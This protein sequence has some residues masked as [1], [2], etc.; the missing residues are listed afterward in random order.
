M[1][2]KKIFA[3]LPFKNEAHNFETFFQNIYD[4][5]DGVIGFDDGSLDNSS[6]IFSDYG[7][8]ML[9]YDGISNWGKGG[10]RLVRNRLLEF[11]RELG[12]T[13]F[14]VLDADEFISTDLSPF[15]RDEILSL[16]AGEALAIPWVNLWKSFD[17][18][19][20]SNTPWEP[21][22]KDFA[23]ADDGHLSYPMGLIHFSRTPVSPSEKT[24]RK[25]QN[26]GVVIH[27]QFAQWN[28]TK[29]KQAWYRCLE[30]VH[31]QQ[32][33]RHINFTYDITKERRVRNIVDLNQ[34]WATN[35]IFP[36]DISIG[37]ADWHANEVM[38]WFEEFGIEFF[39]RLDIWDIE[40]FREKYI[41][42][43]GA[44]PRKPLYPSFARK[45]YAKVR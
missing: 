45:L 7:G 13:H 26:P 32:K 34:E 16:N 10:Q 25:T 35:V 19:C 5:V 40:L 23:F 3:L 24:W 38:D 14:L 17:A 20:G 37:E 41:L 2:K 21:K 33:P 6:Q 11:G 12:G 36:V 30:L 28:R 8:T 29:L 44:H 4:V 39:E 15:A 42:E 18:R 27:T 22:L 9:K 1:N 43:T 31:T